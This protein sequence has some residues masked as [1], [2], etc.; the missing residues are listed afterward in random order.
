MAG[1]YKSGLAVRRIE[2]AKASPSL[3]RKS[4]CCA[5][6]EGVP[7]Q[8]VSLRSQLS[9]CSK[10]LKRLVRCFCWLVC[11]FLWSVKKLDWG[12]LKGVTALFLLLVWLLFFNR[13][14]LLKNID[15]FKGKLPRLFYSAF[16]LVFLRL[17][18]C[19]KNV[20]NLVTA[21]IIYRFIL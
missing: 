9:L 13:K 1:G 5:G 2:A 21:W 20:Q 14:W 4:T 15:D 3:R 8:S 6:N 18:T 17:H 7:L 11:I 10:A 19:F 16:W 12:R